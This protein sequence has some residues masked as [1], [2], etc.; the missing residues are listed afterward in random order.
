MEGFGYCLWIMLSGNAP[1]G[2]KG[3]RPARAAEKEPVSDRAVPPF[4]QSLLDKHQAL[5]FGTG[6]DP[7]AIKEGLSI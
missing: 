7:I 3:G 4:N 6:S 2:F 5:L 1:D